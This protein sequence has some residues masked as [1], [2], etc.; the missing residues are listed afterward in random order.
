MALTLVRHPRSVWVAKLSA[1]SPALVN[2]V[3]GS[4]RKSFWSLTQTESEISLVSDISEHEDFVSSEGPWTV[5]QVEGELD[6]SLTGVL[7]SLTA[8]MANAGVSIFAISTYDTDYILVKQEVGDRAA[9]VWSSSGVTIVVR[10][11]SAD[12]GA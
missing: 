12:K 9:E 6:F 3:T 7:N 10:D 5:F 2:Q 11:G 8:P 4:D 1:L